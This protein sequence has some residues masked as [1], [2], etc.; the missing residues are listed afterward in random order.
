MKRYS[1]IPLPDTISRLKLPSIGRR[2]LRVV[3]HPSDT[4]TLGRT[5]VLL[6]KLGPEP[7]GPARRRV[8]VLVRLYDSDIRF[9]RPHVLITDR[10][11]EVSGRGARCCRVGPTRWI[12]LGLKVL[13]WAG[14]ESDRAEAVKLFGVSGG[15]GRDDARDIGIATVVKGRW[16]NAQGCKLSVPDARLAGYVGSWSL[17]NSL[18]KWRWALSSRIASRSFLFCIMDDT[19]ATLSP[20]WITRLPHRCTSAKDCQDQRVN[21]L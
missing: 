19:T 8:C 12:C 11:G 2:C 21:P 10:H 14:W 3:S 15:E 1:A 13:T 7:R 17:A 18:G 5:K 16:N 9:S 20:I 4:K 6:S